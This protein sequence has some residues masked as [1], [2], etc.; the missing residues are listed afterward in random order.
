VIAA[1]SRAAID[2]VAER[3]GAALDVRPLTEASVREAEL[4][5]PGWAER[6]VLPALAEATGVRVVQVLSAGTDW[7]EPSVPAGAVLCN[8]RGA[9]DAPVAE[10]VVGALL[11]AS[12]GLL[13][14]A[15]TR[16][17]TPA[18][19][20]ELSGS[21][22]LVLGAGSIGDA[23]RERLVP[24]GAEVVAVA[25][26]AR[27]GVR[28]VEE[29]PAL[30]PG[31]DALV[32]LLPLTE[33]TRGMVD[34][35]ALAALPDGALVLN[36][37]RGAVLDTDALLAEVA[38]GRLR[39]VLDVTD[40]EPLPGDHPLW[41]QDGVLAITPHRAGDSEA[42]DRRAA[43]LAADQLLRAARGAPLLNVVALDRAR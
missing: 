28:A 25:R 23:V 8:A 35:D 40:P 7:I 15:R 13:R 30:L 20:T 41:A 19:P 2:V 29:L 4:V 10:W 27:P 37:G 9:R 12:A 31:A 33:A 38:S 17:W 43:E 32:I 21:T 22:V 18:P 16:R 11:G 14:A 1:V 36:A 34:A 26:R 5:V 24:F 6:E 39:A 42:A 3:A